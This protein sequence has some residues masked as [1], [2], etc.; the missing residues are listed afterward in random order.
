MR[1]SSRGDGIAQLKRYCHKISQ[2]QPGYQPIPVITN[3][4]RWVI[5]NREGV[6]SALDSYYLHL[7]HSYERRGGLTPWDIPSSFPFFLQ[8]SVK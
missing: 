7:N 8:D 5:F 2:A 4:L 6:K 3:G 1:N